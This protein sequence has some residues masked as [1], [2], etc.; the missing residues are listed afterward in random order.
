MFVTSKTRAIY[1][2]I[3]DIVQCVTLKM[4]THLYVPFIQFKRTSLSEIL[5]Y[6][7]G[8]PVSICQQSKVQDNVKVREILVFP[9]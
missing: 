3:G 8:R 4:K 9:S 1:F 5:N 2:F 7:N 6:E